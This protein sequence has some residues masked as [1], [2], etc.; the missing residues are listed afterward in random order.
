MIR[1][2]NYME[3]AIMVRLSECMNAANLPIGFGLIV[4]SELATHCLEE[5][6]KENK[7]LEGICPERIL[8]ND[9]WTTGD[10]RVVI[11]PATEYSAYAYY[12]SEYLFGKQPWTPACTSFAIFSIAYKLLTGE[13]PY[14]GNVPEELLNSKNGLDFIKK[15]RKEKM[16]NLV[17]I[18]HSF[19]EFFS[20]GLA[21]KQKDR[22][23]AIGDTAEEFGQ[24]CEQFNIRELQEPNPL[25]MF[26]FDSPQSEFDKL[27]AQSSPD[28]ALDVQKAEEGS[29]DDLVGLS[30]LKQYLRNGVLAVLQNPEKA[31][32]Y[33][34]TIPNGLLLYGPPGCGKTVIAK[35]FAAECR[36]NYAVI[37]TPDIASTLV[38]GTQKII[39]QL[40]KQASV[41]APIVLIF[42]EI[43]TMVPDRNLPDNVK[44][45]EDTNAFLSELCTCAER[46][47]FVIGTTNRPTCMDSAVLR[48]GRFDK[49][50]YVPLPDEQTRMEIFRAYLHERPIEKNIDYLKLGKMTSSGYISSDI[51]QICNEVA[52]KAFVKDEIIT[53]DLIEQVI[54]DGGPSVSRNELR[55]YEESRRYMEPAA[56]CTP[57]INQIGFR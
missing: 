40:F 52:G 21:L 47:I 36:M 12:P 13:L 24:L 55:S 46:G 4:F 49:K 15:K 9:E 25:A 6:E 43:E 38:H 29:L 57:Y 54:R 11:E 5:D 20:T 48:S 41:F 50:I 16:L 3:D 33:K 45:A 30:D 32:K 7:F 8:M 35:K 1:I 31:K 14:I 37:N 34:L 28:F 56:K 39:G 19:W 17:D 53:Q 2:D 26:D 44:V 10:L 22:Y 51:E 18:P 23:Q 27:L 42:D